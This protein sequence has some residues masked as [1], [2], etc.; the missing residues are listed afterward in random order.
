MN[1]AI[2]GFGPRGLACLENA[3]LELASVNL[4]EKPH[5]LIFEMSEHI[6][7]GKAWEINQPETNYINISDHALQSL[8]GREKIVWDALVIP[9]FPSYSEW[10]LR[11][12]K[13]E[14]LDGDKDVYPP[15]SQMGTYL[16]K[17]ATSLCTVLE[18]NAILT[19]HKEEVSSVSY[20]NSLLTIHGTT[21]S[22]EV[23]E[24]LLAM[25]HTPTRESDETKRFKTHA[26]KQDVV[27]IHNPYEIT[28][29]QPD[30]SGKKVLIKGFGLSMLD[31][32]RQLT[33]YKFGRFEQKENSE[34]LQFI[35]EK[36]CTQKIIPYSF[37][38]LPCIPKPFGRKIDST[39]EPT[40][41]QLHTFDLALRNVLAQ[42]KKVKDIQFVLNAFAT[43]AA[44]IFHKNAKENY[45]TDEVEGLIKSWLQNTSTKHTLILDTELP[46][47]D[48]MK[49]TVE[50]ALG[51]VAASLDFTIGQVWRH[52][53][54][55][56]YRLFAFSGISGEVMKQLI[57]TDQ[58][59]K[60]YSFG[61]PVESILQLIAL[62][63]ASIL[64]LDFVNNPEITT[65]DQGWTLS[66]QGK[67]CEAGILCNSVM[68]APVL[69]NL[70]SSLLRQLH[71]AQL[72][73]AVHKDLGV[74]TRADSTV[75]L[76][77]SSAKN[78][79]LA[80]IG[81]N[82]KGSVLGTDAILECFSPETHDW[83]K[84]LAERVVASA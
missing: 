73:Q 61:P 79:P 15:R 37:D 38:G 26:K 60:R 78:I 70:D 7:T 33:N 11:N 22:F 83:A 54:P 63:E 39:F 55:T 17:R 47:V 57:D 20:T 68:D 10:C 40:Q 28:I 74:L 80:V 32:T 42:P 77:N 48:Y 45:K 81:R 71:E 4:K 41:V 14:N 36:K 65:T 62:H 34:Y 31:I 59:T 25:G 49:Q 21:T 12:N 2:I 50:M 6:G 64:E 58:E 16:Y 84:G 75:I 18:Q 82:A 9:S 76:P 3:V 30:M 52:I 5:V 35:A 23:A 67:Q 66:K 43:V 27:Y 29:A 46:T 24:C 44:A 1:I 19:I 13:E 56:L 69:N 53:Q 8:K 72:L 51:R